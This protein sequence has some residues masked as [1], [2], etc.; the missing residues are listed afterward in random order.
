MGRIEKLGSF[1]N[2]LDDM[3]VTMPARTARCVVTEIEDVHGT[4]GIGMSRL[5]IYF[6]YCE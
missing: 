2:H 1:K 5:Q 6:A 4:H 3:L